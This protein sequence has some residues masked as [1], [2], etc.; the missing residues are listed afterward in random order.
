MKIKPDDVNIFS[1]VRFVE[2]IACLFCDYLSLKS[3]ESEPIILQIIHFHLTHLK[4][5]QVKSGQNVCHLSMHETQQINLKE[6][7]FIQQISP[8]SHTTGWCN[9]LSPS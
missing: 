4:L 6:L 2:W 7:P 5:E 8:E 9:S 3:I 1:V